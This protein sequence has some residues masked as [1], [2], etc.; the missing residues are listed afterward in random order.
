[1]DKGSIWVR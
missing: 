1:M